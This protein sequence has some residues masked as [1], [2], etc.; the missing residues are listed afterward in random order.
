MDPLSLLRAALPTSDA[1]RLEGK[2]EA[3]DAKRGTVTVRLPSGESVVAQGTD[4]AAGDKVLVARSA[5]GSWVARPS[6]RSMPG[7]VGTNDL[8]AWFGAGAAFELAKATAGKDGSRVAAAMQR[9]WAELLSRP[10]E[11]VPAALQ[12]SRE[13]G[14][15]PLVSLT[16]SVVAP[17]AGSGGL[18]P[19]A[20]REEAAPG[21]Y[22]AEIA[23]RATE[24]AG[25]AGLGRGELGL[26]TETILDDILSLWLPASL[27][28]AS[29]PALPA[30]VSAD[31]NG[32]RRLLDR[33]GVPAP[34]ANDPSLGSLVRTLVRA[35]A[36]LEES[37]WESGDP[38][39]KAGSAPR[40]AEVGIPVGEGSSE[41]RIGAPGSVATG[42]AAV[43][44]GA[45]GN[46]ETLGG[47]GRALVDSFLED[48]APNSGESKVP[49]ESRAPP[50]SDPAR[51]GTSTASTPLVAASPS[52]LASPDSAGRVPSPNPGV[53]PPPTP[54]AAA[55]LAPPTA[56]ESVEAVPLPP[57]ARRSP[58]LPSATALRVLLAWSMSE[59]EPT[60]A[61]LRAALGDAP[62][63]SDALE[64]LG[65]MLGQD[66][67]RFPAVATF[68]AAIEPE[69]P[70]MPRQLGLERH[71]PAPAN[72]LNTPNA[73]TLAEALATD[74]GAAL[75]Q[76][77]PEDAQVL[78]DAL[79]SLAS[80]GFGA[81][82]DPRDPTSSSPWSLAPHQDRPDSGKVVVHDRR[83]HRDDPSRGTV[84]EVAMD[85]SGLGG[86]DAR[87]ELRGRDLDVRFST[88]QQ[89]TAR[90]ISDNLPELRKLL[91]GLG[92]EPRELDARAGKA[93][94]Q[95]SSPHK[96]DGAGALDIRA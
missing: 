72:T 61:A 47:A 8:S 55:L 63:L 32:A 3:S 28:A 29:T 48:G 39:P 78:R 23:G 9:I 21:I 89:E 54:D 26:W 17:R 24:L 91:L 92:F 75:A 52:L 65:R 81:A 93:R 46:L 10:P 59:A 69:T 83:R 62:D 20:L 38:A 53:Q 60:D 76:G 42:G 64:T 35:A 34:A 12:A 88:R 25:P 84:V 68:L 27:E 85:P 37:S 71:T 4:L 94:T 86:V 56:T 18:A 31:V 19:L 13:R 51:P 73:T 30:R 57:S 6:A 82:R 43:P 22:R 45:V 11:S 87:L 96:G 33:L 5:D 80:E 40:P 41:R 95:R 7:S 67:E 50:P 77:R 16:T 15:P 90:T 1:S 70:L 74:L 66:P 49:D 14:L 2:V 79:R 58:E 36:L 44:R